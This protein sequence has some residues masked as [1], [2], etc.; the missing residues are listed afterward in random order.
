MAG[1]VPNAVPRRQPVHLYVGGSFAASM[2]VGRG[3]S[4]E[5]RAYPPRPLLAVTIS[6]G[7]GELLWPYCGAPALHFVLFAANMVVGSG[8]CVGH[9]TLRIAATMHAGVGV[10]KGIIPWCLLPGPLF[11][12]Y[13]WRVWHQCISPPTHRVVHM[14]AGLLLLPSPTGR[15]LSHPRGLRP[16]SV[17]IHSLLFVVRYLCVRWS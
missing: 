3:I 5:R 9:P 4:G 2:L 12:R 8:F 10:F 1:S 15:M 7:R 17:K 16:L 13:S 11:D 14:S 6:Y